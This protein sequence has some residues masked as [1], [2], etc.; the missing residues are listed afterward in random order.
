MF[1]TIL[2]FVTV[3]TVYFLMNFIVYKLII[4]T[5]DINK[6]KLK[7]TFSLL[8]FFYFIGRFFEQI[9]LTIAYFF[10]IIGIWWFVFV[11][12]FNF[13]GV[14][15]FL[16]I[17]IF[18]SYLTI[19]SRRYLMG[20]F[21]TTIIA[22]LLYGNS[23]F[24]DTKITQLDI[25]TN[26][27][28]Q[29]DSLKIVF[30]SDIHLGNLVKPEKLEDKIKMINKLNP[31]FILIGGD[32]FDYGINSVDTIKFVSV[33]KKLKANKG[34]YFI[35]GNHD[36]FSSNDKILKNIKKANINV[37]VDT[38][39]TIDNSINIVGRQDRAIMRFDKPRKNLSQIIKNI[40]TSKFT[41]VL[42]HQPVNFDETIKHNLDLQLS[43]HTH[44]GQFFPISE[45]TKAIYKKSWGYL[46]ENN[47]I[48]Y[49]SS[50]MFGWGPPVRTNSYSEIV[51]IKIKFNNNK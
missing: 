32:L 8:S 34:I 45:I 20:F 31:D 7:I 21:I 49:V 5:F 50:G 9:N 19:K 51:F 23:N 40:D 30:I 43:G 44:N 47:S 1:A 13:I 22:I 16:I 36:L 10:E 25:A 41:I 11:A 17:K 15:Y 29:Y 24:Y 4:L 38:S 48:L 6:T 2:F 18:N 39:I 37:L 42:D 35:N 28:S 12:H 46:K 27:K 26:K 33:M 14:F 3:F